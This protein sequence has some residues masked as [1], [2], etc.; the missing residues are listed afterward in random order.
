M[1]LKRKDSCEEDINELK[2]LLK[3]NLSAKQR[4]LVELELKATMSGNSGEGSSAY[5]L[6]FAYKD[7]KNWA[8]I[9][10]LRIEHSG[11]VAQIDHLLINRFLDIYVL[12]SKNYFYGIKV[13]EHGE[14][15]RYTG[16]AFQGIESP[17]EQNKRHMDLLQKT[18]NDRNLA[19]KRL[20]LPIPITF[21]SF[22][23]VAPNSRIDRPPQKSFDTTNVIKAD[24]FVSM[25]DKSVDN[26]S[27]V[28]ALACTAK[29]IGSDTL[30][31]FGQKLVRLHRPGKIN[32]AA[33]F[34]ID[35]TILAPQLPSV[36]EPAIQYNAD[37][38]SCRNCKSAK[39]AILYGKYG[40]YFKCGDCDG[41]TPIKITCGKEGHSERLRKDGNQFFR[42]CADCKSSRL[43]FTNP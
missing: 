34:A 23:L 20:S 5:Y 14:F 25:I 24:A 18:I 7:S 1:I 4:S 11:R 35:E 29:L 31:E 12:E 43:Y 36:K 32:Y 15:L 9:H 40:Y 38:V 17:I 22:V 39:L 13:T 3:L 37:A 28:T 33:K 41:N 30:E 10:D 2:R 21:K 6:D 26:V 19:P 16:K 27:V 8:V 42:E